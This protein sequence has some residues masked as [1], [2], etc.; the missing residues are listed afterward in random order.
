MLVKVRLTVITNQPDI[1]SNLIEVHFSHTCTI[2]MNAPDSREALLKVVTQEPGSFYL[3]SPASSMC[4]FQVLHRFWHYVE[5]R[6][7]QSMG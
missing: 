5:R 6:L 7:R 1:G 3:K 2:K 4:G